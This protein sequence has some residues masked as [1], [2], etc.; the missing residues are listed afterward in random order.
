LSD[1]NLS[2]VT[3]EL[4]KLGSRVEDIDV[5]KIIEQLKSLANQ[6]SEQAG[7]VGNQVVERLSSQ[8]SSNIKAD[9]EEYLLNSF[10]WHFNRETLQDEFPEVIYDPNADPRTVWRDLNQIDRDYFANL[11]KQRGD[12]KETSI[13]EITDQLE[14]IR[15]EVL[16]SIEQAQTQDR[17]PLEQSGAE[18]VPQKIQEQYQ[19][20]YEQTTTAIAEYLRNTNLE[21]L[22]P[23]GIQRDLEKLFSQPQA[24]VSAWRDRLQQVDRETLVKLL[25]QRED[26]SEE[27]VNQIID[28][29]QQAITNIITAP[30]RLAER[31][32]KQVR[33]FG[34]NLEKYLRQTNKEELN[35]EGIKR[36]LQLLLSSPRAGVES[37]SDRLSQFDRSTLIALLSQREDISEAEANRIVDQIES[38]RDSIGAQFQ[39]IQQKLREI[40]EGTFGK[41]REYLNSLERPELNYDQI[42]QDF[43]KLFDDPQAGL[44]ALRD[45]LSQFDRNT[46]VAL[47]SSR[48]DISPTQAN[49]IINRIESARDKVLSQAERIQQETQKRLRAIQQQVKQQA[50]DSRKA[51][52]DAAWWLF[53][54]AFCSLVASAIAGA[55]AVNTPNPW[56]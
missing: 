47:L 9:V 18:M 5:N 49:Q 8:P 25:S 13:A 42:Q 21:E 36:D 6:T 29:T 26:L 27:Q 12:L 54:A 2:E 22:N 38:V 28:S 11:L 41:I 48:P 53:N 16:Q 15:Q 17:S 3:S 37:L 7:R 32:T 31:T 40:T 43:A 1:V 14:R 46:L 56:I 44:A 4:K 34:A 55:I 51:A 35:P 10:P 20:Q 33:D 19:E 24:G 39:Q 30:R 45:R 52:T 50:I 23:E